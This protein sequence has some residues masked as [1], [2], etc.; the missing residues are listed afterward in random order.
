MGL[1]FFFTRIKTIHTL[2]LLGIGKENGEIRIHVGLVN[3]FSH[4]CASLST[5]FFFQRIERGN[6]FEYFNS[7]IPLHVKV[8]SYFTDRTQ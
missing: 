1:V 6:T 8:T 2:F 5:S 4:V 3:C 7:R